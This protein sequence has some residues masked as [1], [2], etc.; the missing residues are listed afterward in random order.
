[1]LGIWLMEPGFRKRWLL[2]HCTPK[3]HFR[4]YVWMNNI[5]DDFGPTLDDHRWC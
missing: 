2:E 4:D 1:M 3:S 5:Y